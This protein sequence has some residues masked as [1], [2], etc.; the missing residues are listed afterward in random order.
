MVQRVEIPGR[1]PIE[2]EHLLLDV[3]GTLSE[4][5]ELIDGVAER[6]ERLGRTLA[7]HLLSAD[8]FGTVEAIAARLGVEAK[9]V[10]DGQEK[11]RILDELGRHRCAAVGNGAN[12]RFMVRDAALG[13]AVVGPEGASGATITAADVVCR[14]V[15]EALDLLAESEL[16]A[17]TLRL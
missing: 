2:L 7:V 4:R 6:L 9:I 1:E 13:I 12:D 15:L 8:T 11:L 17:A 5:G 3:N 16:L 10:A 14:S